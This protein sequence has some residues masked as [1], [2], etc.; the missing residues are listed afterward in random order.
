MISSDPSR[1]TAEGSAIQRV[2]PVDAPPVPEVRTE[3]LVP[4]AH[5]AR[6]LPH[7]PALDGLRGLALLLVML[8]HT[9]LLFLPGW[10]LHD[11]GYGYL[12]GTALGVD[13]FFVLSG[14]LIT[15]FFLAKTAND[16]PGKLRTFYKG[17]ALRLLPALLFL[18]LVQFIYAVIVHES[19]HA[20]QQTILGALLYATNWFWVAGRPL[21]IGMNHLWTLSIEEQFYL[22]WPL[23]LLAVLGLRRRT[24]TVSFVIV[25]GVLAVTINRAVLWFHGATETALYVRT[26]T[27]ADSLLIGALLAQLWV[28]GHTPRRGLNPV[29]WASAVFMTL[30]VVFARPVRYLV[31]RP[32]NGFLY[33]GGYTL[34]ALATAGLILAV[35]ER[36][37]SGAPLVALRPLRALG[38]VSYSVYL[39]HLPVFFAVARAG[40]HL[41]VVVEIALAWGL[42]L[43]LG[44][45][46]WALVE[47]PGLLLKARIDRR[48]AVATS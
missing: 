5:L 8:A 25:L 19:M 9:E 32:Q 13:I 18:L 45:G 33:L 43:G 42:S 29:G 15:A 41:P 37:W 30:C 35:V 16:R 14:F 26:D 4:P 47:R 7:V 2:A 39:W 44:V 34:F 21:A 3:V 12:G 27:R 48:A 17:R 11:H 31:Y 46:A 22:L 40:A 1:E 28:R 36:Q 10:N 20:E 24:S 38:R 23:L 6:K